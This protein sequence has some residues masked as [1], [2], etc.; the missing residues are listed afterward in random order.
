ME[1]REGTAKPGKKADRLIEMNM[2]CDFS[3]EGL[4]G[5]LYQIKVLNWRPDLLPRLSIT[6]PDAAFMMQRG[7][8]VSQ[9]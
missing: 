9:S 1:F 4:S 2:R 3:F 7:T 5:T 8:T 6:F